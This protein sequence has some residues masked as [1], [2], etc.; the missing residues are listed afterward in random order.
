MKLW[1][2]GTAVQVRHRA[3]RDVMLNW[4][5]NFLPHAC[6]SACTKNQT[7]QMHEPHVECIAHVVRRW[8]TSFSAA[9]VH[10]RNCVSVIERCGRSCV[11]PHDTQP[12]ASDAASTTASHEQRW[13]AWSMS[14]R[15]DNHSCTSHVSHFGDAVVFWSSFQNCG[16]QHP[17]PKKMNWKRTCCHVIIWESS[18]Q[19]DWAS[20]D[21]F[22]KNTFLFIFLTTLQVQL[23]WRATWEGRWEPL[24][25]PKEHSLCCYLPVVIWNWTRGCNSRGSLEFIWN[26]TCECNSRGSLE[27]FLSGERERLRRLLWEG[28]RE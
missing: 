19:T 7:M 27:S 28:A 13:S 20:A 21:A 16:V 23:R 25:W 18:W 10:E 8:L 11:R 17:C 4:H 15:A 1:S 2:C 9:R 6:C 14:M 24:A 5:H 26:R 3:S 12:I 22:W